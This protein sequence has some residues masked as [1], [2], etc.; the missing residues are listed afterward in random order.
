MNLNISGFGFR[1]RW[2]RTVWL[3]YTDF[4]TK[5]YLDFIG[6]EKRIIL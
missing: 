1:V 5:T 3:G 2:L 6:F 4:K